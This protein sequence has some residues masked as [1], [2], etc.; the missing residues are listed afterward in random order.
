MLWSGRPALKHFF[1]LTT[2]K[3]QP[4]LEAPRRKTRRS[5]RKHKS[6]SKHQEQNTNEQVINISGIPLTSS[7]MSVLAK[8]S[9]FAPTNKTKEFQT[10]VDLFKF[11]RHLQLKLWYH[12]NPS[13]AA[14]RSGEYQSKTEKD[15]PIT[16]RMKRKRH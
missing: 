1:R 10:K 6:L 16:C 14:T 4:D 3:S 12:C 2:K 9:T 11:H 7:Q 5:R 15:P 8:G 13:Q